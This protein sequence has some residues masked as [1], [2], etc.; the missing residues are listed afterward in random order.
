M[1]EDGMK[2]DPGLP[3]WD[4]TK[5]KY[6]WSGLLVGNGASQAVWSRFGYASL[7]ETALQTDLD[8]SLS[9]ADQRLFDA[10]GTKNFE[11]V[12]GALA[13]AKM[14]GLALDQPIE[15]IEERYE[16]TRQ[17]LVSAVH[18][19]HIPWMRLSSAAKEAIRNEM[20]NYDTVFST[21]YDLLT[22]W[23][24]MYES[25]DGFKDYF[26]SEQFDVSDVEIWDKCTK[27]LYLHGGLHLYRL[28]YGATFKRSA[29][30]GRNLLDLFGTPYKNGALPLFISEGKS[31][32]KLRSI[33]NSDY[34]SFSFSQFARYPGPMVIFG[35]GLHESDSHIVAAMQSWG[36]R[37]IAISMRSGDDKE[38]MARKASLLKTLPKANL[39][40][41]D[42]STHPLGSPDLRIDDDEDDGA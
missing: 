15:L 22:Y 32:D 38:I 27:V 1:A 28:P 19:V 21:N 37:P 36:H 42:A 29:A 40:F 2:I 26:W 35:Q 7:Y 5:K 13:V 39:C 30:L 4:D 24:I 6:N 17:A 20:L 34:L 31:E 25:G 14:V 16:S 11:A 33:Y 9:D 8:H 23:A 3:G 12:L 41:F 18:I 10:M